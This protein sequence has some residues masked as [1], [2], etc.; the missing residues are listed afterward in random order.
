MHFLNI[1]ADVP[2]QAWSSV[3]SPIHMRCLLC[4]EFFP[5]WHAVLYNWLE[6]SEADANSDIVCWY[7]GW[8][9]FLGS[10]IEFDGKLRA[11]FGHALDMMHSN[12]SKEAWGAF[13]PCPHPRYHDLLV[14]AHR[15][16]H[17]QSAPQGKTADPAQCNGPKGGPLHPTSFKDIVSEFAESKGFEF[18]PKHGRTQLG[19]MLYSF[20]GVSVYLDLDVVHAETDTGGHWRPIGLEELCSLVAAKGKSR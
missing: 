19:K 5:R 15:S 6:H 20:G 8:K 18:F 1:L 7:R 16:A 12:R 9:D 2:S 4:G 10:K 14:E 17:T 11:D 3:I 13:K